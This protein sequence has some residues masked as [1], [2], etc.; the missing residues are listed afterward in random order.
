ME[1]NKE[2][3]IEVKPE[4]KKEENKTAPVKDRKGLAIS[5][6]VLGIIALVFFCL[7]Y[8]SIPCGILAIVFGI[9]SIKSTGKGMAIAGLVTGSI[10]FVL[11]VLIFVSLFIFGFTTAFLDMTDELDNNYYH[12]YDDYDMYD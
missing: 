11:T 10:G 9:L 4:E 1:E 5:S 7:W 2:E 8:I 6:M 12:S 3:I